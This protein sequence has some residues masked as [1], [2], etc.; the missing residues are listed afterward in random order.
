MQFLDKKGGIRRFPP[1]E[2]N[3][4]ITTIKSIPRLSVLPRTL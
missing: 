1:F 2:I 4:L 3:N